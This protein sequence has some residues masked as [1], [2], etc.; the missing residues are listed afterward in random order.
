MIISRTIETHYCSCCRNGR[1]YY[2]MNP[3]WPNGIMLF[4]E[5]RECYNC[6]GTGQ[7][8]YRRTVTLERTV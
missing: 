8:Q 5:G 7:I 1:H 2:L 4:E 3:E 6:D